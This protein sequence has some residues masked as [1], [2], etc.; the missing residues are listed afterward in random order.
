M[1]DFIFTMAEESKFERAKREGG[2][3]LVGGGAETAGGTAG[4]ARRSRSSGGSS[5]RSGSGSTSVSSKSGEVVE[6]AK[7]Q[8]VGTTLVTEPILRERST[9]RVLSS[10]EA[11]KVRGSKAEI[12]PGERLVTGTSQSSLRYTP[13]VTPIRS[14]SEKPIQEEENFVTRRAQAVIRREEELNRFEEEYKETF[15]GKASDFLSVK[16][17]SGVVGTFLKAPLQIPKALIL[18]APVTFQRIPQALDKAVLQIQARTIG[19]EEQRRESRFFQRNEQSDALFTSISPLIPSG[20]DDQGRLRVQRGD[21]DDQVRRILLEIDKE[22]GE[23]IEPKRDIG[24]TFNPV[25]TA[26]VITAGISAGI[27]AAPVLRRSSAPLRNIRGDVE[28]KVSGTKVSGRTPPTQTQTTMT[29][30]Q[31]SPTAGGFF[32]RGAR[33][34]LRIDN[35]GGVTRQTNVGN[36]IF[37]QTQKPGASTSLL[38]VLKN[39]KV[40]RTRTE[41]AINLNQVSPTITKTGTGIRVSGSQGGN[42]MSVQSGTTLFRV[43]QNIGLFRKLQGDI[44]VTGFEKVTGTTSP[45]TT[46]T[47]SGGGTLRV[48]TP[49]TRTG[50][51]A[52][53]PGLSVISPSSQLDITGG[54]DFTG[55]LGDFSRSGVR[56]STTGGRVTPPPPIT[57]LPGAQVDV[58][59]SGT[60]GGLFGLRPGNR[61]IAQVGPGNLPGITTDFS[62]LDRFKAKTDEDPLSPVKTNDEVVNDV[63]PEP[64]V[65]AIFEPDVVGG[66]WSGSSSKTIVEAPVTNVINIPSVGAPSP[67]PVFG[68]LPVITG[69][70]GG[71]T[72]TFTG[73]RKRKQRKKA[74]TRSVFQSL[75]GVEG[76]FE[77]RGLSEQTGLTLRR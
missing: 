55:R 75:F 13:N 49:F 50:G 4:M 59:A 51:G 52:T 54:T 32:G 33:T 57:R 47:F 11:R 60:A 23:I 26:N 68:G 46:T 41:P 31:Q 77:Q 61:N 16:P 8:K 18:D 35:L 2:F 22:T 10:S 42:V 45:T 48:V 43:D 6:A 25:G 29:F 65:P 38:Q 72:S 66:I 58:A 17:E 30:S 39:G 28:V 20:R 73:K 7:G 21:R 76:G 24:L 3:R 27:T 71:G 67:L 74:P 69:L 19:S 63:T 12:K 34:Q 1:G 64:D 36:T 70:P 40:V 14:Q 56:S 5:R 44:S 53:L 15:L 37:R 62:F 9:G